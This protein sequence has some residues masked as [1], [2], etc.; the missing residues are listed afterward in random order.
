MKTLSY[1]I[2]K[3]I[4]RCKHVEYIAVLRGDPSQTCALTHLVATSAC[5]II[6]L[7][8]IRQAMHDRRGFLDFGAWAMQGCV[9]FWTGAMLDRGVILNLGSAR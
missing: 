2:N 3:L 6:D 1:S 7:K 8:V 4:R 9:E 5:Y